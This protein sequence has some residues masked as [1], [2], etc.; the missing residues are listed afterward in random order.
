[1]L[2]G[3]DSCDEAYNN[4]KGGKMKKTI[5]VLVALLTMLVP[6]YQSA[7]A[8]VTG[9]YDLVQLIV[10]FPPG[11]WT[12]SHTHGGQVLVTVL[13]GE[14][15]VRDSQGAEK[16]YKAGASFVETP[17]TFLEVGNPGSALTRNAALVLLPKGAQLTTTASGATTQNAPPGPT[18][19]Y[20]NQ[21]SVGSLN[22]E[23]DLV[24][25]IVD[26][27]PGAWT[28]SHTHGGPVLVTVVEGETTTRDGQGVENK[29]QVGQN[30]VETPGT[31]LEVGNAGSGNTRNAA[32]VLLPKG[33]QVTTT[34]SGV[35]TQN[36]PPGPT[37]V[38]RTQVSVA[39]APSTLPTTGM[40]PLTNFW[41]WI[42]EWFRTCC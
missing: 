20:R 38:Y 3:Y 42:T 1:M 25:L 35:S 8:N 22:G 13:E 31:Y 24:Q 7:A 2:V 6:G 17:G 33:A 30:F 37:T 9:E 23:Y 32:G 5:V 18:T 19:V 41:M 40:T 34:Q 39:G 14:T 26:F 12:P 29:I 28:P 15:T 36:A 11:T 4:P 27:A 21:T 16:V 10:D